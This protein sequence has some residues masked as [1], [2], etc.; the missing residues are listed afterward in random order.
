MAFDT[1][2][3]RVA[4]KRPIYFPNVFAPDKPYPNDHFTGFSG[5]AADQFTILRIYDRWGGLIFERA[6]FPLNDPNLGW[7][8]TY[9][10]EKVM[11]VFAWYASVRF[12]DQQEF[13]YEGSVTVVR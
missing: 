1:V 4:N 6:D 9:K 13:Q 10:G 12:V 3:I 2:R 7:D 5:P 11:G 8:G